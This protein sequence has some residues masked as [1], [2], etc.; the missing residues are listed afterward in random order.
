MAAVFLEL[1]HQLN[2]AV[3]VLAII[4]IVLAWLLYRAGGIITKFGVF[5]KKNDNIDTKIETMSGNIAKIQATTDLLYQ[6]HLTTVQG[7]SPLD[8]TDKGK[9]AA[10]AINASEKVAKHWD[11]IK[12]VFNTKNVTNPYDIQTVA[13]DIAR[14]CFEQIFSEEE[15]NAIKTYAYVSGLNLLEIY[16]I[17]GVE[18]RNKILEERGIKLDD[19][20]KY[21]PS[22]KE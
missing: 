21:D 18:I 9:K 15:K 19:I 5:E 8:L 3:F 13:M 12:K 7:R 22:K 17:I 2:G 4:L 10:K 14:S 20:D 11:E 16:P 6:A 1:I